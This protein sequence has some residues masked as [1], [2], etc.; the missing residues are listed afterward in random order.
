MNDE[1]SVYEGKDEVWRN[2]GAEERSKKRT[3]VSGTQRRI[4]EYAKVWQSETVMVSE[5]GVTVSA[6][7]KYCVGMVRVKE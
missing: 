6:S 2:T 1:R 5:D 7:V 3:H 4:M